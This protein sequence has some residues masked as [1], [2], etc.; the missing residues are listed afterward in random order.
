MRMNRTYVVLGCRPIIALLL[1]SFVSLRSQAAEE[2]SQ[3]IL[4]LSEGKVLRVD[5]A[6]GVARATEAFAAGVKYASF[7][8]CDRT[9]SLVLG[10]P[11][12]G[13]GKRGAAKGFGLSLAS[14]LRNPAIAI[15]DSSPTKSIPG[16]APEGVREVA[17]SPDGEMIALLRFFESAENP[18][19][20]YVVRSTEGQLVAKTTRRTFKSHPTWSPD[21]KS[22]AFYDTPWEACAGY[23]HPFND[24]EKVSDIKGYAVYV[25]NVETGD[26]RVVG[27][28]GYGITE[29]RYFPPSWS[30]DG[31][32]LAFEATYDRM[33]GPGWKERR[34][35]PEKRVWPCLHVVNSDGTGLKKLSAV[36]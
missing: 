24:P 1:S 7:D 17:C 8:W 23:P 29:E 35:V 22:I 28:P 34:A 13:V 12:P 27:P 4:F 16:W 19:D 10:G 32:K 33:W 15:S 30:P 25:L 20:L 2:P 36:G 6:G 3:G 31:S 9:K 5:F 14:G 18:G 21:G 11:V 26:V